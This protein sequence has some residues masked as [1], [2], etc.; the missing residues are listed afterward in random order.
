MVSL[1]QGWPEAG[2]LTVQLLIS[3]TCM[4]YAASWLLVSCSAQ[5]LR[6]A[7]HQLD[8]PLP[9]CS[10]CTGK[11]P[12][13]PAEQASLQAWGVGLHNLGN[14][15]FM[16]ATLQCLA[17]LPELV[18]HSQQHQPCPGSATAAAVQWAEA[19]AELLSALH[20]A[21]PGSCISPSRCALSWG[22][23][24]ELLACWGS[25][26]AVRQPPS[27]AGDQDLMHVIPYPKFTC[28]GWCGCRL[29]WALLVDDT[30][31]EAL[32]PFARPCGAP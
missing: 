29:W 16:N 18:R 7:W 22:W 2:Q 23:T 19:F 21:D 13:P 3:C 8:C 28:R 14:T 31:A 20:C 17:A 12:K 32:H 10:A 27:C 4:F 9:D 25:L 15:C 30:T 1:Q 24:L 26:P 5:L 11:H 6:C